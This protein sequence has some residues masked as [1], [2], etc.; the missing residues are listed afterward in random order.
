MTTPTITETRRNAN[1]VGERVELARYSLLDGTERVL[2]GQRVLGVVRFLPERRVVLVV[3]LD[4]SEDHACR[5]REARAEGGRPNAAR[6]KRP[7]PTGANRR[8]P[9]REA[10]S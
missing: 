2:H 3:P 7:N 9:S 6:H 5:P 10:S 1:P 4:R 8:P